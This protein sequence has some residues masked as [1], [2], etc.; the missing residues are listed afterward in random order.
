M[1]VQLQYSIKTVI[2]LLLTTHSLRIERLGSD[3]NKYIPPSK[4]IKSKLTGGLWGG[5]EAR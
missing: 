1:F 3:E 2:S 5:R 4:E